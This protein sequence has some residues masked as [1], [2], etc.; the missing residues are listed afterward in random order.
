V[1]QKHTATWSAAPR[2]RDAQVLPVRRAIDL[3]L[4]TIYINGGR[5]GL[6]VACRRASSCGAGGDSVDAAAD[7]RLSARGAA[8]RRSSALAMA[9]GVLEHLRRQIARYEMLT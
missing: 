5:P 2:R 9:F 4:E 8:A 6:L 7:R 1:A 3:D